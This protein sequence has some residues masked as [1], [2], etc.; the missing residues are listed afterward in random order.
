M[1]RISLFAFRI[2]SRGPSLAAAPAFA[3]AFVALSCRGDHVEEKAGPRPL[4]S[5]SRPARASSVPSPS[6]PDVSFFVS[7]DGSGARVHPASPT[8]L[9]EGTGGALL[10]KPVP[11]PDQAAALS[12]SPGETATH[13]ALRFAD[14]RDPATLVRLIVNFPDVPVDW[15]AF[16]SLH[17]QADRDVFVEA[18]R[19]RVASTQSAV[20]SW[21]ESVGAQH[22]QSSWMVNHL[23]CDVPAGQ[24]RALSNRTVRKS[25]T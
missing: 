25:A 7:D 2:S 4:Q 12:V 23:R 11:P 17:K 9:V 1:T 24:A 15:A 21:L 10:P 16:R 5:Q 13:K 18:Q 8:V 14:A 22:C 20:R 19:A 6:T 3:L